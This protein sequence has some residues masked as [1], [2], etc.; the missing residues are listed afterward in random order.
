MAVRIRLPP[1]ESLQTFG[2]RS[3]RSAD[4]R[5]RHAGYGVKAVAWLHFHDERTQAVK[6]IKPIA[7]TATPKAMS[8]MSSRPYMQDPLLVRRTQPVPFYQIAGLA[9][10]STQDLR[11]AWRQLHRTGP[12]IGLSR[13]LLIRALV[14]VIDDPLKPEE[15]LSDARRQAANEWYD[16]TLYSRL[17]DKRRGAIVIVMQRLHEDDLVGHV[18]EQ[19]PW[20]VLRFPAIAEEDEVHQIETIWGTRCFTRRRGEALHPEREPLDTLERICR[21]LGEYGY[22]GAKGDELG[23]KHHRPTFSAAC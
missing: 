10:R 20:E 3:R 16:H 4:Y 14:I 12:P 6:A 15:A 17:N 1:A 13:D 7:I 21:T 5:T 8:R 11:V 2:S 23:W 22:E 18:L 9:N 19:E